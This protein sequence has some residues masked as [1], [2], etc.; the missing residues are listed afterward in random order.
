MRPALALVAAFF[1]VACG[2]TTLSSPDGSHEAVAGIEIV[3][4][5]AAPT[6][7]GVDVSAGYLIVRNGG[8]EADTLV[9]IS[10]PRAARVEIHEMSMEG[11]VMRMRAVEGGLTIPAH[12]E[13]ALEPGGYHLMFTGV[14]QP[15]A[16]GEDIPVTLTFEHA[17]AV[18]AMLPVGQ[19]RTHGEEHSEEGH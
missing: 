5:W 15:F 4:P 13:V 6:P 9:S 17:G 7:G 8:G 1:F 19:A 10:S 14:T 16:I 11:A 2:R 3:E 12:G 18:E